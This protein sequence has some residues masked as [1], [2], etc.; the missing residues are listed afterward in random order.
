VA[1]F[2]Q[3]HPEEAERRK[4]KQPVYLGEVYLDRLYRLGL[5]RPAAQ[6]LSRFQPVRRDYSFIF[7]D[8]VQWQAVRDALESLGIAEMA[9]FAPAEVFRAGGGDTIPAAHYSMLVSV[10]YQA[11]E[12]TL[13]ED[14]LQEWSRRVTAALE[15]LGGRMRA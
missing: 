12:R 5:K 3:L 1:F 15:T 2:G 10:T 8:S 9:H 7:P 14:E 13:Q 4:I 11:P 6:E